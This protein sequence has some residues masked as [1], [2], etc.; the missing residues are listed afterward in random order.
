MFLVVQI[1]DVEI[2]YKRAAELFV[3][4]TLSRGLLPN[5]EEDSAL[6]FEQVSSVEEFGRCFRRTRTGN[7]K[8]HSK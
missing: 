4:D 6:A 8:A 1:Y 7:F 3:A 5:Q 2:K